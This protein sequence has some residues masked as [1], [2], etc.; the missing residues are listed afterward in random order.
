M[1][2]AKRD[3]LWSVAMS[4]WWARLMQLVVRALPRTPCT[5]QGE[6]RQGSRGTG[7]ADSAPTAH[8]LLQG[9]GSL[10]TAE[11]RSPLAVARGCGVEADTGALA[12]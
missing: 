6:G 9:G 5:R 2:R 11:S 3:N 10:V 7:R 4:Y 1:N 12:R 8:T